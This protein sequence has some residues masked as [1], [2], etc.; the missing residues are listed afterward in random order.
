MKKNRKKNENEMATAMSHGTREPI[1]KTISSGESLEAKWKSVHQIYSVF[2]LL[3]VFFRFSSVLSFV[4]YS[5][6]MVQIVRVKRTVRKKK[7]NLTTKHQQ[8]QKRG[9]RFGSEI[10]AKHFV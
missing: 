7:K 3:T 6:S 5:F 1:S 9:E 4:F 10:N 8:Q 2:A